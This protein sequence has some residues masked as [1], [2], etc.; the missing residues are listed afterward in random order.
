MPDKKVV[1][2]SGPITGVDRYWEAFE[3]AD[4]EL[5]ARGFI[6]LSPSRL[7]QG[8]TYQQYMRICMAMIDS[9]DA[10]LFLPGS[11]GSTGSRLERQY[12]ECVGKPTS[13]SID[14]LEVLLSLTT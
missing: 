8:M 2:I 6:A 1:F 11:S 7:P 3:K 12:A 14:C 10:V 9:A 13:T 4:D 5:T